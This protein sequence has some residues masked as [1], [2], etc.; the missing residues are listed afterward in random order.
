[1][2]DN[3]GSISQNNALKAV[4]S[5]LTQQDTAQKTQGIMLFGQDGTP[6]GKCPLS[7][8]A[9]IDLKTGKSLEDILEYNKPYVDTDLYTD[10]GLPSGTLW[11]KKNIDITQQNGFAA[12]EFQYECSFCSW[13]N[14]FMHNPK[15]TSSFDYNWGGVN[16]EEPWYDGQVYGSTPGAA[17]TADFGP[18]FDAARRHLGAPWRM[19][20]TEEYKE[21]FDNCDFIDAD[22]NIVSASTSVAGTAADKRIT[23]NGIVGLRLRSKINGNVIFFPASGFGGGTSWN[24]RGSYGYY[25]SSSWSSARDARLLYFRSGGVGPQYTYYRYYGFSVRPVQ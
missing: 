4:Q 18:S 17:L 21:L 15:D 7:T 19:P 16:A 6:N 1:M 3:I 2:P 9:V 25:W 5:G 24:G 22:G 10:M 23:M 13:G 14:T 12:S 8:K 20:S 11:A